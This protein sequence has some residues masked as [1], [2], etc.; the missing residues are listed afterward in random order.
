MFHELELGFHQPKKDQCDTYCSY[1]TANMTK[2]T[3]STAE[4]SSDKSAVEGI[5]VLTMD[6]QAVLLAPAILA[7]AVYYTNK[8]CCHNFAMFDLRSKRVVC[9]FW[10]EAEGGLSA[11]C[12]A[13][14]V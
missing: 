5:T 3:R 10:H 4:K 8:L 1:Q 11:N 9:Y 6:L 7:S 13:P 2:N 12:F 14:C